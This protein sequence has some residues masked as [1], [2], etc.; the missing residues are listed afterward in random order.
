MK[1]H[2]I[3]FILCLAFSF[4]EAQNHSISGTIKDF[5]G[6][7]PIAGVSVEFL[8]LRKQIMN[9]ADTYVRTSIAETTT[10][11]AGFYT[12]SLKNDDYI[13]E[14]SM[15]GY[16]RKNKFI[17][18]KKDT[19]INFELSEKINQLDDVE[20]RT[21]KAEGNVKD[22]DMG[23]IKLN[24][25][26]LKKLPVVF[27]ESDIIRALTLQP[28]VTTVG[29]GAGGFNVRGGRVDQNLVLIDDAPLFNTSHLL[30][31][32]TSINAEAIQSA[33]LVKGGISARFGGRLSS[34]LNMTTKM[35]STDRTKRNLSVGPISSNGLIQGS[36]AKGKITY[37]LAGRAAYPN[38]AISAFPQRFKNSK[39][40]FQDVN[41]ALQYRLNK[42]H[43]LSFTGYQSFDRFKFPEDTSYF[44]QN[45]T[46]TVQLSG[47]VSPKFSYFIKGIH[48]KYSFGVNGLGTGL[49]YQFKSL[50]QH[51]EIKTELL[52]NPK[53]NHKI[54]AGGSM[55]F[56]TLNPG[57]LT[58]TSSESAVNSLQLPTENGREGAAFISH[59]WTVSKRIT[60]QSGLRYSQFWNL[61]ARNVLQYQANQPKTVETVRDTVKYGSGETIATYGGFEPRVSLKVELSDNQ[62]IKLSYNRTRQYINLISN[63]TAISP[64]DFWKLSDSYIPGQVSDQFAAGYYR[65]FSN[66]TVETYIEGFY[67]TMDNLVE[68]KNGATLLL[69]SHLET[70]LLKGVGKSYGVEFSVN[71]TKGRFTGQL[72]YTWSRSLIA[73]ETPYAIERVNQGNYYPSLYDKPHNV[74][75]SGQYF[76]G[77]GWSFSTNFVYQTGRPVT[78]PD[79]QYTYNNTLAFNYATR[80]AD[81]LPDFHRLDISFSRDNRRTKDQK[82]YSILNFSLYN[83]YA[84]KNPYSIFFKQSYGYSQAYRLAVLGTIVPSVTLTFFW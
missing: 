29:E 83:V 49:E 72:S 58:P 75:L 18:L 4:C 38:W 11:S 16:V 40:D 5:S 2:L 62:S 10:D 57:K 25:Q 39:A 45:Q 19:E 1:I 68:Y 48:S 42:T 34:L 63:T 79:G 84:R 82:V 12:Y 70:E 43:S 36:L 33:T 13:V 28:G 64:V 59:E 54:E 21:K 35:G 15:L 74:A 41:V 73:V 78:Y 80:N 47:V 6:Q 23:T 50:V 7:K 71:K 53:E 24:I 76:L 51:R 32:F 14:V 17:A 3:P 46:A 55:I 20:V 44:W 22:I 61:G 8:R 56:Y 52:Y 60:L 67:K 9:G 66:N 37:M 77:G 27:G 69:N 30:G 26:G 31:F 81:R 65:N